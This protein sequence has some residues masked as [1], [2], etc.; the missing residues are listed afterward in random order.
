M[1]MIWQSV[2]V[3]DLGWKPLLVLA[4]GAP[5][6]GQTTFAQELAAKLGFPALRKMSGVRRSRL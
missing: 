2:T 4:S 5:G 3:T 6:S 1:R